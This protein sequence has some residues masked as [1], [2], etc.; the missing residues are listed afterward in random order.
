MVVE[1]CVCMFTCATWDCSLAWSWSSAFSR[2]FITCAQVFCIHRCNRLQRTFSRCYSLTMCCFMLASCWWTPDLQICKT[3]IL[4]RTL[5]IVVCGLTSHGSLFSTLSSFTLAHCS[6]VGQL[7]DIL[8]RDDKLRVPIK[9]DEVEPDPA[10][11]IPL[12]SNEAHQRVT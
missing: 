8:T 12:T 2:Q 6:G 4:Y 5:L 7:R 9:N 11:D 3:R 10:V 1:E